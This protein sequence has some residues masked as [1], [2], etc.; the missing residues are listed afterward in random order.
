MS[1]PIKKQNHTKPESYSP[2]TSKFLNMME[3]AKGE[4]DAETLIKQ[5]NDDFS[6][7]ECKEKHIVGIKLICP[8]LAR[9]NSIDIVRRSILEGTCG[10]LEK[11]VGNKNPGQYIAVM[12]DIRTGVDFTYIIGVEVDK[13]IILPDVLPPDTVMFTLPPTTFGKRRKKKDESANN[14]LSSF[15]YSD[16]RKD[17]NYSYSDSSFPFSYYN[18]DAKML[19]TY[20]PV[21]QP[22]SEE[23]RYDSVGYEIVTLPDVK[24]IAKSGDNGSC[25]W[26]FFEVMDKAGQTKSAKLHLGNLVAFGGKNVK[27]EQGAY[28][29]SR[30]TH[31]EDTPEGF[32][33][34]VYP[35]G[36]F[37]R[38]YQK[39]TNN[40]NAS[41][42]FDGGIKYF[43]RT[44]PEYQENCVDGYGWL[45]I[46][47]YEQ[48]VEVYVPI[49]LNESAEQ[50]I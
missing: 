43:F 22:Q 46:F 26:K 49:K 41:I 33:E 12:C 25:M 1:E 47:Q 35:S 18:A 37:A 29:G 42:L 44:H 16:F 32:D 6:I 2:G 17:L 23:E 13:G 7:V 45:F 40:D 39:Q 4:I 11:L 21:K 5:L 10:L 30:V 38:M 14:A 34:A 8:P 31:F 20:Q 27:G 28:F 36:L 19:Y 24:I 50:I 9:L 3:K 48:G 15:S